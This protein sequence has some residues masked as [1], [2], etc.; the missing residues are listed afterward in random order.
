[1]GTTD[2]SLSVR[3]RPMTHADIP[4]GMR[5]KEL[6]GW[7]QTAVD[8][9]LLLD[10]GRGWVA[11]HSGVEV[12]TATL[13]PYGDAF[14]WIGMVLVDPA[15]RRRGVGTALLHTAIDAARAHGI[16][17]LDATPQGAPLYEALGF[18]PEYGISRMVRRQASHDAPPADAPA[19]T[20]EVLPLDGATLADAVRFDAP[21][22]GAERRTVL[23]AL[24]SEARRYAFGWSRG[25]EIRGYC[26]GRSG[27]SAEQIGPVVAE[28]PE[29]AR[30][31]LTAALRACPDR[32]VIVDAL[33]D[34]VGWIAHLSGLGFTT[35]RPFVRMALGAGE[36]LP[37][38]DPTRIYA[39]AGPELG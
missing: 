35:E 36:R 30:A 2:R 24:A 19:V 16:A 5:L 1:M 38:G 34:Q 26:L 8:W 33:D 4:L 27:S 32:P 15:W 14:S 22:F 11:A 9:R 6:A 23:A 18:R 31:L 7:N 39:I 10:A 21:I 3:L 29:G 37:L 17:R 25:G 13:L 28:S 12:G 20:D